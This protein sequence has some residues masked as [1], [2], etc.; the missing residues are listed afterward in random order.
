MPPAKNIQ[1]LIF[2]SFYLDLEIKITIPLACFCICTYFHKVPFL[3]PGDCDS[4]F[5]GPFSLCPCMDLKGRLLMYRSKYG[6]RT[7]I[8][9]STSPSNY[10]LSKKHRR[11]QVS[12][13]E[14]LILSLKHCLETPSVQ[15]KQS[16]IFKSP[17][18]WEQCWPRARLKEGKDAYLH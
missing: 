18:W 17:M 5:L 3:Y 7:I 1:W 13:R 15:W 6:C 2:L 8:L 9:T 16:R 4:P 10:C 14:G 11:C 12:H